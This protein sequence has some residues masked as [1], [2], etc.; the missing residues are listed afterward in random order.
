[1]AKLKYKARE[2]CPARKID[3]ATNVSRE[4]SVLESFSRRIVP[5][6]PRHTASRERTLPGSWPLHYA[7]QDDASFKVADLR[8]AHASDTPAS[9]DKAFMTNGMDNRNSPRGIETLND[10]ARP[11]N[12]RCILYSKLTGDS[13][14][15]REEKE[16]VMEL[17]K[18]NIEKSVTGDERGGRCARKSLRDMEGDYLRTDKENRLV[19]ILQCKSFQS[20]TLRRAN[21]LTISDGFSHVE[22]SITAG[23]RAHSRAHIG[24]T[25]EA[26]KSLITNSDRNILCPTG[27][28]V[29]MIFRA[30]ANAENANFMKEN[31]ATVSAARFAYA[32]FSRTKKLFDV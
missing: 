12:S 13:A 19:F 18:R 10:D 14:R 16:V 7:A 22:K 26:L 15:L 3:S 23:E 5:T 31:P 28:S 1:M 29:L 30:P 9:G 6:F 11:C 32:I 21:S 17:P 2:V 25:G 24:I 8:L 4:T 27:R 20:R